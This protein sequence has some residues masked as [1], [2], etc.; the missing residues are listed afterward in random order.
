MSEFTP[1]STDT[2]Q[3]PDFEFDTDEDLRSHAA[4]LVG[5]TAVRLLEAERDMAADRPEG[6]SLA[7]ALA[8]PCPD[9]NNVTR[10][11]AY[12]G[13]CAQACRD[14]GLVVREQRMEYDPDSSTLYAILVLSTAEA[15]A[16][17]IAEAKA[18]AHP[19]RTVRTH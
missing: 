6:G 8:V 17:A 5:S 1:I 2:C 7:T 10:P 15:L 18:E 3:I 11:V 4:E 16:L 9:R 12:L 13:F 19:E 14:S